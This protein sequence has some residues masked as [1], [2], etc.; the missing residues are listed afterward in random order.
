LQ[1]GQSFLPPLF[2]DTSTPV[3]PLLATTLMSLREQQFNL[4]PEV[5]AAVAYLAGDFHSTGGPLT[6]DEQ[7]SQNQS[8]EILIKIWKTGLL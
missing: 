6:V 4:I 7:K 3:R 8:L 5:R 2:V 1:A